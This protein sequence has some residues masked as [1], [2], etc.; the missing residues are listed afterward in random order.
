MCEKYPVPLFLAKFNIFARYLISFKSIFAC[1]LISFKS[2]G[3][4]PFSA[5]LA[6][7]ASMKGLKYSGFVFGVL[8]AFIRKCLNST[9][10]LS[11][12]SELSSGYVSHTCLLTP[13]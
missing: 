12:R 4:L 9:L 8:N 1:Y 11:S 3:Y 2:T 6:S 5:S 7:L 10:S 13:F